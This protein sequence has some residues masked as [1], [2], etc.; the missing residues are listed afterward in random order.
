MASPSLCFSAVGG[1]V[2]TAANFVRKLP[3]QLPKSLGGNLRLLHAASSMALP[4]PS[5]TAAA[6]GGDG[7]GEAS[8]F[9]RAP[10]V[11]RQ[12]WGRLMEASQV[13]EDDMQPS[14]AA[15]TR[16]PDALVVALENVRRELA[17]LRRE[18]LHELKAGRAGD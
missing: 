3:S 10:S 7:L 14:P 5:A 1:S 2:S 18:V 12:G 8:A 15:M 17:D 9:S 13:P 6:S 4:A 16:A 11:P